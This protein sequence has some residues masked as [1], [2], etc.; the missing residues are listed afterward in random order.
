[1]DAAIREFGCFIVVMV[2]LFVVFAATAI[3]GG[4]ANDDRPD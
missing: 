3:C 4:S 2:I 1:M